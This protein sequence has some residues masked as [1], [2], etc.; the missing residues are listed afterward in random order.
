LIFN[1]RKTFGKK[2]IFSV[3]LVFST[4]VEIA[5]FGEDY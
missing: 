2:I 5:Y 4:I 1:S 3:K